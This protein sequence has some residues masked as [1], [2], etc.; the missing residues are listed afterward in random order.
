MLMETINA[1][2]LQQMFLSGAATLESN[3]EKIND[4]N[5]FPV[6][7][8]D[9]G[10][11]MTMTIN[12]AA[13]EVRCIE[14]P[15]MD[16][17][18][19]AIST[20][21]LRGARGNSGVILSQLFRGFCKEIKEHEELDM[22]AIA[23]AMQKAT[24]TAYKAVMKP[25]EGTILTVAR[26]IAE[27]TVEE[28]ERTNNIAEAFENVLEHGE[29]V[30][31]STPDMLP[32]LKQA[33][34]VDSGG[35][36]LLCILY[37]CYDA[38][39]GKVSEFDITPATGDVASAATGAAFDDV[40]IEFGYCTEF[41]IKLDK[42]FTEE[43]ED[44]F[45]SYLN[46]VGDSIVCVALDDIVKIH[47]H[48]NHPGEVFEKGLTYGQL[49]RMKVDNMREEHE[50]KI[51]SQSAVDK[52]NEEK[53]NEAVETPHVELK[54]LGVLAVVPGDGLTE[55]FKGIGA[56]ATIS[57]GQTMNPSTE[58]ILNAVMKIP[59]KTVFVL[60]NNSNIILAA[61]QAD[62]LCDEKDIIVIP[63]KTIPQG[64]SALVSF[65][66]TGDADSNKDNMME[67]ID[68]V[69]SGQ[70]TYAVR[71]TQIDGHDVKKGDYIAINDEGLVASE[72]DIKDSVIKMLDG[73]VSDD[74]ELIS[75]YYG[76]DVD[77]A[78]AEAI[79]AI[80]EEKYSYLDVELEYGGQPVY[81]YIISVE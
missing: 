9:T 10:T 80:V 55:I 63:T 64:I 42:E 36:G 66:P 72:T 48:T 47:V 32:V 33:G 25:K 52:A 30:L 27:K 69:L 46:S 81:Y 6:P 17:L 23:V 50:N 14:N 13:D 57:G 16:N 65:D 12:S 3:K 41:I 15:T 2:M 58:D 74:Y 5:V 73:M 1:R 20:G 21:S 11:N 24:E 51:I 4:L 7:D 67:A 68:C 49:S 59:A 60:P 71:D 28:A 56:D 75:I 70:V 44:E 79:A 31:A 76:S 78:D 54:E 26:G 38:L 18:S 40:D 35:Q 77:E 37:G 62:V 19:K 53:A 29:K 8:G 61:T 34:V 39:T 45:K 43:D 22:K